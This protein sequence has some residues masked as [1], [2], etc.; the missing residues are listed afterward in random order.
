MQV[1]ETVDLARMAEGH[2][3]SLTPINAELT[4][5]QAADYLNVSRPIWWRP[6]LKCRIHRALMTLPSSLCWSR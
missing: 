6:L 5:R 2:G 3:V 1:V 4:I